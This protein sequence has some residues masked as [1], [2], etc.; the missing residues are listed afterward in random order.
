[1]AKLFDDLKKVWLISTLLLLCLCVETQAQAEWPQWGGPSRNF[2]S[3][4]KGLAASWPE[5]GPRQLWSRPLGQGHSSI[6]VAGNTLYTMY[7]EGEQEI[8]VVVGRRFTVS[9]EAALV[10]PA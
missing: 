3:T 6:V 9:V 1:M 2:V 5:K 7:S 4:A 10:L 8:V